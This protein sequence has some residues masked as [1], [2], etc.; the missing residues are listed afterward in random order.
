MPSIINE[1]MHLSTTIN[2]IEQHKTLMGYYYNYIE[3]SDMGNQSL[4]MKQVLEC[5]PLQLKKA[6][7]KF[8]YSIIRK[9]T[10]YA[11]YKKAIDNLAKDGYCLRCNK[12][13]SPS[14]AFKLYMSDVGF[15]YSGFIKEGINLD[16]THV[17]GALLENYVAQTLNSLGY[18][19]YFWESDS[20]AKI[21]FIIKKDNCIIPIEVHRGNKTRSK[22]INAFKQTTDFP[23]AIKISSKNFGFINQTKYLPY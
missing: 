9:G 7:K 5:L 22:S 3:E 6:N 2:L 8:Q 17:Q 20:T 10:T 23:Y 1:Y 14:N 4:K 19:L 18:P 11:M 15:L 16:R 12:F 21:E 13:S